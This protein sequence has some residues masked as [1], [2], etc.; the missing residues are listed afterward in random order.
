MIHAWSGVEEDGGVATLHESV[1]E[2]QPDEKGVGA[3]AIVAAA[4]RAR[5]SRRRRARRAIGGARRATRFRRPDRE[6]GTATVRGWG[7][8]WLALFVGSC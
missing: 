8:S 4:A 3:G 2:V 6:G 7:P 5:S 1:V